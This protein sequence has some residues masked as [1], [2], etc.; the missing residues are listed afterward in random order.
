MQTLTEAQTKV[1]DATRRFS[2]ERL[3]PSYQKRECEGRLDREL[4]RELG[5]LGLLAMDLPERYGGLGVDSVT[6]GLVI[7][8]LAHGD[9]NVAS[10]AVVQSLCGAVVAHNATDLVKDA[11]LPRITRG[12][13]ILALAIT[14]PKAGSD[15]SALT[16]RA[17]RDGDDYVLHGEKTSLTF[18]DSADAFVVFARTGDPGAKGITAFLVP[19]A[20]KGISS[21]RFSD[22]GGHFTG[23]GSLF[24]DD[25]RVPVAQR[26]GADGRGFFEVMSGFDYS[27]ALIALQCIGSAQASVDEAPSKRRWSNGSGRRRHSMSCTSAFSPLATMNGRWTP[28]PSSFAPTPEYQGFDNP[29]LPEILAENERS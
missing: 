10:L 13:A 16:L 17:R 8:A 7:E 29:E 20:S 23:R 5:G 4:V 9:F 14:E 24:F 15:A 22:V 28:S 27:R 12:E 1:R 6:T 21:T 2:R 25:V 19:S 11:W 26:L 18:A 3:L